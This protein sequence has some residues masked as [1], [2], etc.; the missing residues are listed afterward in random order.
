MLEGGFDEGLEFLQRLADN[1]LCREV[2]PQL[3]CPGKEGLLP[4]GWCSRR[5]VVEK[6]VVDSGGVSWRDGGSEG[7][8]FAVDLEFVIGVFKEV[9]FAGLGA[10]TFQGCPLEV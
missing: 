7:F 4:V 1:S 10:S 6:G 5:V 2:I 3:N 8:G 9:V